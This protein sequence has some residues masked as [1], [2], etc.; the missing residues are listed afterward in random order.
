MGLSPSSRP[1][2]LS[3]DCAFP[4]HE[5]FLFSFNCTP[6]KKKKKEVHG[7]I[8]LQR[9]WV[10]C[11]DWSIASGGFFLNVYIG[12]YYGTTV[13]KIFKTSSI[14]HSKSCATS[15]ATQHTHH[16]VCIIVNETGTTLRFFPVRHSSF[17][18]FW[19]IR[20]PSRTVSI[21]CSTR[22]SC[23]TNSANSCRV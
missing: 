16:A 14:F 12:G 5:A 21:T 17:C 9:V 2:A 11:D 10:Y 23:R 6:L 13:T 15:C 3:M 1:V 18:F 4:T 8:V 22:S 20:T 7:E 19:T